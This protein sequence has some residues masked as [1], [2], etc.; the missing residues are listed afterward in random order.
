MRGPRECEP[1]LVTR[2][3]KVAV[4]VARVLGKGAFSHLLVAAAGNLLGVGVLMLLARLLGKAGF[5]AFTF[6]WAVVSLIGIVPRLGLDIA[7]VRF[8]AELRA[9]GDWLGLRELLQFSTRVVLQASLVAVML[10]LLGLLFLWQRTESPLRGPLLAGALTIPLT[11]A[12]ALRGGALQGFRRVAL[13]LAPNL[14]VR[15]LVVAGLALGGWWLAG[16]LTATGAMLS[17]VGGLAISLLVAAL[18]L[19]AQWDDP[20]EGAATSAGRPSIW[21]RTALP[22]AVTSGARI[23]FS[24]TDLLL[25][26]LLVGTRAAGEY[27]AA[28]ALARLVTAGLI[29]SNSI[30]APLVSEL[31]DANDRASIQRL[32]G[33]AC[34]AT[35][36]WSVLATLA[37][38][39]GRGHLLAL[40]GDFRSG[41]PVLVILACGLLFNGATGPVGVLL[42]MTGHERANARITAAVVMA[43]LVLSIPATIRYGAVGAASV[44]SGVIATKNLWAWWEVRRRLAIDCSVF[45]GGESRS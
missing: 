5:G 27:A 6:A 36:G 32:V 3:G 7:Q 30:T 28:A 9:R 22:L 38:V 16:G 1:A 14:V 40:F 19:G 20:G 17:Q 45:G 33:L 12:L 13:A 24:R 39:I 2:E 11:S 18:L 43:N 31:R 25:V 8:V 10:Y 41:A 35:T 44:T 42:N 37:I 15:P 4:P 26:G 21:L 23:L 29:A 34:R